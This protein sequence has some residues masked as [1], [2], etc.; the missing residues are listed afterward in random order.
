MDFS[1]KSVVV[2]SILSITTETSSIVFSRIGSRMSIL[3]TLFIMGFFGTA[4]SLAPH[5][6]VYIA[7]RFVVGAA[8]AGISIS[9]ATLSKS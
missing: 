6:Y 4:A 9:I 5:F 1:L 3:V 2:V 8:L 7:L